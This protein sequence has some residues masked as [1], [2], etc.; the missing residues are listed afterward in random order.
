MRTELVISEKPTQLATVD[1]GTSL[2]GWLFE[3]WGFLHYAPKRYSSASRCLVIRGR[4]CQFP[5]DCV[6]I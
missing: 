4:C 3:Y 2:V 5:D 6:H 1:T